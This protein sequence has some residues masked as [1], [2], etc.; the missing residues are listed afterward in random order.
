MTQMMLWMPIL[1]ATAG[2]Y[3]FKLAGYFV[4]D[5]FTQHPHFNQVARLLPIGLLTGL[6][7]VQTF[8][9]GQEIVFDGRI[10][11]AGVAIVLLT[12]KAP[13]IVVVFTAAVVTAAG[14]HFGWWI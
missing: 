7:A 3:A 12:R 4:P 8:A 9:A 1:V 5:R 6:I 14:R 13:F 11:G 10:V 2:T